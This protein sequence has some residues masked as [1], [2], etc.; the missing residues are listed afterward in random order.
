MLQALWNGTPGFP[1]NGTPGFFRTPHEPIEL[2]TPDAGRRTRPGNATL[3]G[4][5]TKAQQ[6][7]LMC[8]QCKIATYFSKDCHLHTAHRQRG[9]LAIKAI[10]NSKR[11]HKHECD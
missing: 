10:I 2:E 3:C 11:T 6:K 5:C 1:W 8:T 4:N 7:P 9:G